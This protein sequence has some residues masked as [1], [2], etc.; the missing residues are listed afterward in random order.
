M[1][2]DTGA[3]GQCAGQD[4]GSF[5]SC[6]APG[7]AWRAAVSLQQWGE[8]TGVPV[9]G[10]CCAVS[11]SR[12]VCTGSVHSCFLRHQCDQTYVCVVLASQHH[13]TPHQRLPWTLQLCNGVFL[14]G[15]PQTVFHAATWLTDSVVSLHGPC[16]HRTVSSK[17]QSA[18]TQV[19]L[20]IAL[21]APRPKTCS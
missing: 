17:Q 14:S 9:Q 20:Y 13:H 10:L 4:W 12:S 18:N 7:V 11:C 19:P 16:F 2:V 8:L 1:H 3:T 6:P 21:L 5:H 15:S